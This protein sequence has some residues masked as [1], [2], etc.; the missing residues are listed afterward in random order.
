MARE[1][2]LDPDPEKIADAD[3][4]VAEQAVSRGR[5]LLIEDDWLIAS[6]VAAELV[7]YG[8]DIV[9][10]ANSVAQALAFAGAAGIDAALVDLGLRGELPHDAIALLTQRRIPFV[11]MTAH[12]VL[13]EGIG[14]V[15][16]I[17]EKPFGRAELLAALA[18]I[19]PTRPGA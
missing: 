13:P 19:L 7:E 3:R 2:Y 15:A 8:Y 17:L 14:C 1:R 11:Y 9:G 16:P 5:V 6:M 4:P 10:P 12:A 18:K